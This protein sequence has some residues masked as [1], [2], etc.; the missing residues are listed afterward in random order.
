MYNLQIVV[1]VRIIE[2]HLLCG[3]DIQS[4]VTTENCIS[5]FLKVER[6]KHKINHPEGDRNCHED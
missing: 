4:E 2:T 3:C 1:S 6:N 5:R